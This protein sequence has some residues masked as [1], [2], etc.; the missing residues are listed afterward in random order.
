MGKGYVLHCRRPLGCVGTFD[1]LWKFR[2]YI[3]HLFGAVNIDDDDDVQRYKPE[4]YSE[5]KIA[6]RHGLYPDHYA[7]N[8]GGYEDQMAAIAPNSTNEV[9]PIRVSVRPCIGNQQHWK[10]GSRNLIQEII[11]R[12]K[13]MMIWVLTVVCLKRY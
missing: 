5:N 6:R 7:I 2:E 9:S 3:S 1:R 4:K 10:I 13:H 12:N 11:T 8:D